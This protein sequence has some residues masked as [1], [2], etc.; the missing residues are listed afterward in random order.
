MIAHYSDLEGKTFLVTGASS[1]IGRAIAIALGE[2]N[3]NV[4]LSGRD[5][6]RLQETASHIPGAVTAP[7]DLVA[8]AERNDLADQLPPLDGLCHAAGIINPFPI[9][10]LDQKQFDKVFSINATAPILL[11]SRLLGKKKFKENASL[12]FL[13]SV[14]SD[15]AMKGGSM[16]TIS[17]SALEAFSRSITLE[18]AIKGI[19]A[20]CLRPGLVATDIYTQA[21]QLASAAGS[22]ERLE[23]YKSRYLLGLGQTDDV[24]QAALFL[25]SSASRWITGRDITLDGG[26]GSQI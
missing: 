1:G 18:H 20:N 14:S 7:A 3:A 16:Y 10:Y 26:L 25:L 23:E 21:E 9:R 11:T 12:V 15:R 17:K 24:A 6:T 8:E 5:T 13:S 22:E 2:Q 4:I 19:R